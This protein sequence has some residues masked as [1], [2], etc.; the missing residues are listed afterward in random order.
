MPKMDSNP[1]TNDFGD[2]YSTVEPY[3]ASKTG[4]VEISK[5]NMLQK[6]IIL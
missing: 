5:I 6:T 2:Q 3:H 1:S 4:Y